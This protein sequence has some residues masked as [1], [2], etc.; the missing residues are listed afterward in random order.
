M[1]WVLAEIVTEQQRLNNQLQAQLQASRAVPIY[2]QP[3][4]RHAVSIQ[5]DLAGGPL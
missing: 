5:P 1:T 3:I 4:R 2:R